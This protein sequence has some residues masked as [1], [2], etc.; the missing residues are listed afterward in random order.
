L[1]LFS[2]VFGLKFFFSKFYF[3]VAA[4]N[5][6]QA[7]GTFRA[8]IFFSFLYIF[9]GGI[10][11]GFF[12]VN[13]QLFFVFGFNPESHQQNYIRDKIQS[14]SGIHSSWWLK[15]EAI[16]QAYFFG[17]FKR[18]SS[19]IKLKLKKIWEKTQGNLLKSRNF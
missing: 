8:S 12:S 16:V 9:L 17:V 7:M 4:S 19:K 5:L 3:Y 10:F 15:E 13:L 1:S 14:E 11:S 6:T 18:N 2:P